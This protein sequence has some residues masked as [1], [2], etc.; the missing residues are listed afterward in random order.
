L[1]KIEEDKTLKTKKNQEREREEGI[2]RKK[3]QGVGQRRQNG[4]H[5]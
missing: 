3:N 2:P 1:E 5:G 4:W